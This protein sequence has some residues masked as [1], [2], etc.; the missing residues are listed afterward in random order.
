MRI[1]KSVAC[2]R[3]I[4]Y[5]QHATINVGIAGV[6]VGSSQSERARA[7]LGQRTANATNMATSWIAP[8]K[9]V[10]MSLLPT[11]SLLS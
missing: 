7:D 9:I 8:E 11:V 6:G 4:D 1:N 2:N 3:A 5:L 10:L